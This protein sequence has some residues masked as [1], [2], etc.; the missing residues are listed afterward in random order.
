MVYMGSVF[1]QQEAEI[2]SLEVETLGKYLFCNIKVNGNVVIRF[3]LPIGSDSN[4]IA[5][6]TANIVNQTGL[7]ENPVRVEVIAVV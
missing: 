5:M 3:P 1:E 4:E 2:A 6:R 7:V